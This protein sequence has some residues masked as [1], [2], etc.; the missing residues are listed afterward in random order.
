LETTS[1]SIF[2]RLQLL[3]AADHDGHHAAAG[4]RLHA[5][6]GHLFLQAL[7]H[8]L[9]LFHHRLDVHGVSSTSLISAGKTSSIACTVDEDI[10]SAFRSRFCSGACAEL[11]TSDSERVAAA[12][13]AAAL[14]SD[15]TGILLP[16]TRSAA[17]S[18]HAFC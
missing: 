16:A 1:G 3:L 13:V 15:P 18:S 12:A 2:D 8:L 14:N 11:A 4:R 9:R 6:V 17:A 7:L 10:A 5:E